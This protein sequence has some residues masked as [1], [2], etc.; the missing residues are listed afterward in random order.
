MK[1][2][3]LIISICCLTF[4]SIHSQDAIRY[5]AVAFDSNGQVISDSDIS[6][7]FTILVGSP[8]GGFSY[9]ES[10]NT[11]TDVDGAF[12]LEIGRGEPLAGT[13]SDVDWLSDTHFLQVAV[14][15]D[16]GTEYDDA[17]T[18]EFLSVPCAFHSN[19]AQYG[20]RG[21]RG[22]T[23]PQGPQG[24][25]GFQGPR[26]DDFTNTGS[27]GPTGPAGFQGPLGPV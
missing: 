15:P 7:L 6:V 9:I 27:V 11:T 4:L 3:I 12:D 19:V 16:G 22:A 26:G 2:I 25:A 24:P 23:G 18:Q 1:K 17:G 10:H 21:P 5:Q 20:E 13:L 14:D 8:T